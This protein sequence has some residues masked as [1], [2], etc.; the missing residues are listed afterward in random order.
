MRIGATM[1]AVMALTLTACGLNPDYVTQSQASVLLIMAGVNGGRER[2][3][4]ATVYNTLGLFVR[5]GLLREVLIDPERVFYDTNLTEH[6]HVYELDSGELHDVRMVA[7]LDTAAIPHLPEGVGI[8]D[9]DVM[10]RVS[11]KV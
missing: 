5:K 7:A 9:T 10:F 6:Y 2:V 3:S 1:A 11:S 8:V 4:K